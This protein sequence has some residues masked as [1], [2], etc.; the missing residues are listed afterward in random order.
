MKLVV[1]SAWEPELVFFRELA[2]SWP[3]DFEI[4]VEPVGVGLVEAAIGTMRC[5]T[6]HAPTH[7]IFVGTCGALAAD[8]AVGQVVVGASACLIEP[9]VLSGAAEI[10]LPM[11]REV[12]FDRSFHDAACAVGAKSV[13]IANTVA[14]TIDDTLAAKLARHADVEH[15][16]AFAFARACAAHGVAAAALLGV[17]NEVGG[18]GRA[19]W[20]EHHEV[21]S[22]RAAHVTVQAI[23]AMRA[24]ICS[25]LP[26]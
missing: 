11:P 8:L 22:A 5:L 3:S 1:V 12:S 2:A 10:P 9:D 15:L 4:A 25:K 23:D 19:Q 18:R 13:Q 6:Q 26:P 24:K 7:A 16:E 20:S 21:A 14:I 17:A